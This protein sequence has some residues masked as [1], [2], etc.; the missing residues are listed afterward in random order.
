MI[1]IDQINQS[2]IRIEDDK[3]FLKGQ[4]LP[5]NFHAIGNNLTK[6]VTVSPLERGLNISVFALYN[7]YEINGKIPSSVEECVVLLNAFIGNFHRAGSSALPTKPPVF[8]KPEEDWWDIKKL[9]E[10][11]EG[12]NGTPLAAI[13]LLSNS[14]DTLVFNDSYANKSA[15]MNGIYVTSDGSVY[16]NISSSDDVV[17]TWDK[18]KDLPCSKGYK[19]R[20]LKIYYHSPLQL[21]LNASD[22]IYIVIAGELYNIYH[23]NGGGYHSYNSSIP[24]L[25]KA[26]DYIK[27]ASMSTNGRISLN[28]LDSLEYFNIP[29]GLISIGSSAFPD[30]IL[31]KEV[32]LP[33]SLQKIE[34][35]AF[36]NCYLLSIINI[37]EDVDLGDF[38]FENCHSLA[39]DESMTFKS[40]GYGTFGYCK[41]ITGFKTPNDGRYN[42][43]AIQSCSNIRKLVVQKNAG[44]ITGNITAYDKESALQEIEIEEG[45]IS[46]SYTGVDFRYYNK[47]LPESLIKFIERLGV[48]SYPTT[49]AMGSDNVSKLPEETI[50]LATS[51]N[52]NIAW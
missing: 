33:S 14:H 23:N 31:L 34:S 48:T 22:C 51:K 10:E 17:H 46:Q 11:D 35:S 4:V 5:A 21:N 38:C 36:R 16:E 28:N 41:S 27:G 3:K 30:C 39:I 29:E 18:S 1:K 49:I 24:S 37:G 8:W 44:S 25:L 40:L 20:W 7:E 52:Y 50:L 47:M 12:Y 42:V 26:V 32:V 2:T 13:M 43:Y 6:T 45:W 9:A 19:T 15:I